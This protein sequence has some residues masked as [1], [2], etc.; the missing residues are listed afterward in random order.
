LE[1]PEDLIGLFDPFLVGESPLEVDGSF[2]E[3][4]GSFLEVE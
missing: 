2:L 4:D 1:D 3:V